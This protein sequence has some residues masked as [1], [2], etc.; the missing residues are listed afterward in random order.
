[1]DT[2]SHIS[3]FFDAY[4]ILLVVVGIIATI[5]TNKLSPSS[6]FLLGT[7]IL[8][9]GGAENVQ[10]LLASFSNM[11]VITIF[12]L[13]FI[14]VAI[15]HNTNV[16]ALFDKWFKRADSPGVFMTKLS[17]TVAV[18]SSFLNNTPIVAMLMSNV[19]Q[20]ARQND[21]S[22]SK[23]L[24]PLSYAAILGGMITVIGTSTNLVLM[25][26]LSSNGEGLLSFMDFFVV[27]GTVCLFGILF[28]V[29]FVRRLL[30]DRVIAMKQ[31]SENRGQYIH[32]VELE[33]GNDLEGVTVVDAGLKNLK[34]IYLIE[35]SR[36]GEVIT[37]IEPS[38]VLQKG[39]HLYF[40]GD[41]E[42]LVRFVENQKGIKLPSEEKLDK[43]GAGSIVEV[44]VSANSKLAGVMV[45]DSH[46]RQNYNASIIGIHRNGEKVSGKIG[47][48]K[49]KSGD[50]L[51]LLAGNDF[52]HR[53]KEDKDLYLLTNIRESFKKPLVRRKPVYYFL[54][55]LVAGALFTGY[56]D[57]F[58][59]LVLS[60][61]LLVWFGFLTVDSIK[62]NFN[63]DLLIVLACS[64]TLGKV[65]IESGAA[66]LVSDQFLR[67]IPKNDVKIL[68]TALFAFTV[69]L[70]SLVTNVAAVSIA[71]PIA[72]S[73]AHQMTM[74]G[75]AFYLT[76]AFGA[77]AAFLTPMGYQTNMMVYG[78][79][80]YK[81]TDFLRAGLPM[82]LVYGITSLIMIFWWFEL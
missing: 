50:L 15:R 20:W 73:L 36:N 3:D 41:T 25:G 76:I 39:D 44:I 27:G 54:Q 31:F 18:L 2:L 40:A 80:G 29:L 9:M 14:T 79:G 63:F 65:F 62:S 49:I 8:I 34:G 67:F 82:L 64:L 75:D 60:L 66:D 35:I 42:R 58:F 30:P 69:L 43:V 17:V 21:I 45:K 71:F 11:Q 23:F 46:F 22:P 12:I 81:G 51:L 5:F 59:S 32:E 68:I 57:F 19:Q 74:S 56:F 37:P 61:F 48:V 6:A 16:D 13:I 33:D 26:L 55:A 52:E 24:I 28:Q 47:Y 72:Y 38:T 70:T 10:G 1:M 4:L 77:S 78:P 53:I 7:L